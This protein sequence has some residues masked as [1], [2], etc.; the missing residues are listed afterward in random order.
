MFIKS[1]FRVRSFYILTEIYT[2]TLN[3]SRHIVYLIDPKPPP[4][5][6]LVTCNMPMYTI[7]NLF[8]PVCFSQKEKLQKNIYWILSFTRFHTQINASSHI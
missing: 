6:L 4:M 3:I 2:P 7:C 8:A 5:L 1:M